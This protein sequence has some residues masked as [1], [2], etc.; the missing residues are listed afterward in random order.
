MKAIIFDLDGTLLDT[1]AD[2]A[3]SMNA[4]LES[5]GLAGWDKTQYYQFVGNGLK[6]MVKRALPEGFIAYDE[7]FAQFMINYEANLIKESKPYPGI[8]TMLEHCNKKKIPIA[9]CSN[10]AQNYSEIVVRHYFPAIHFEAVIGDQFDGRHKPDPEAALAIAD[11]MGLDPHEILF[12]GDSDVDMKTAHN[13]GMIAIGVS[14]GFRGEKELS[15]AK[16]DR[17][18]HKAMDIFEL[19]V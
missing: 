12:V 18:I 14:W 17:I 19:G 9:I 5:Y 8:V 13:A 16:A 1:V 2:L 4:V 7:A 6:M 11:K 15:E 10:K 3:N